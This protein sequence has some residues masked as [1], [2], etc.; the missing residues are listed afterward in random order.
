[1]GQIVMVVEASRTSQVV[2]QDALGQLNPDI[3]TSLILNKSH[4]SFG[5]PY[6]D[7]YAG[8]KN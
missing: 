5:T 4:Q 3:M 6:Y 1:M 8:S 2:I 7:Y